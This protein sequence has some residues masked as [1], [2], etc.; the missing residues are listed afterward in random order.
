MTGRRLLGL[1]LAAGIVAVIAWG[2][3]RDDQPGSQ[4]TTGTKAERP[5]AITQT[6][7]IGS[8]PTGD[9]VMVAQTTIHHNFDKAGC[10]LVTDAGRLGDGSDQSNMQQW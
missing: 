2:P 7:S 10:P 8:A 5:S 3:G 4:T 1:T 9:A 6:Q